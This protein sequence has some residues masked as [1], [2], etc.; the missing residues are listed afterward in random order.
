MV[1]F[2]LHDGALGDVLLSLPSIRAVRKEHGPVHLAGRPDV[3]RFLKEVGEIDDASSSERVLFA[4]LYSGN[5]GA[6]AKEFLGTFDKAFIFTVQGDSPMVSAVRGIIRRT[7]VVLTVPAEGAGEHAAGFRMRQLGQGNHSAPLEVPSSY[8]ERAGAVLMR[9][10]HADGQMPL[11][12]IHPGSGSRAKCWPLEKYFAFADRLRQYRGAFIVMLS[13]PAEEPAFKER[14]DAFGK[15]GEDVM[16][17][18]NEDLGTVTGIL[19]RSVCYV[20][21]DS[22]ISHLAAAVGTPAIVLFG[23]TDPGVWRPVGRMVRVITTDDGKIL[24]DLTVEEVLSAVYEIQ[25]RS[26]YTYPPE[27][28]Q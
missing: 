15:H 27:R 5:P 11:I 26:S 17:L 8:R 25:D 13:G 24:S 20:G 16:H 9:V 19:A 14:I 18:G 28:G 22:G 7:M 2:I 23:P 6:D 21:N 12:A 4:S 10:K 1:T 3:A